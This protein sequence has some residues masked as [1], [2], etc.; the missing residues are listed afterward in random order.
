[1]N[2]IARVTV[3]VATLVAFAPTARAVELYPTVAVTPAP[4]MQVSPLPAV[5]LRPV[6]V[7]PFYRIVQSP[8]PGV[9]VRVV[10][11]TEP[12]AVEPLPANDDR[13]PRVVAGAGFGGVL[14][15]GGGRGMLGSD[16]RLHLG[17][18]VGQALVGA[19]VDLIPEG[20][21]VAGAD[22]AAR[23]AH[24]TLGSLGLGYRFLPDAVVHPVASFS[25][26]MTA[27]SVDA[28]GAV[29]G[30][31]ALGF[32]IA[33]RVGLEFEYPIST[34]AV[35][36]GLDVSAHRRL[37]SQEGFP[38]DQQNALSFGGTLHYRF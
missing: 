15:D 16:Y 9:V 8:P 35:A 22:G 34:G 31:T 2:T 30:A 24:L 29:A 23:A 4:W 1:M 38:T 13:T 6:P 3:L 21:S 33:G 25:L 19:R 37:V 36:V 32:G 7:G 11:P 12:P 18:E 10:R 28:V 5:V 20:L 27:L 17:L 14:F 26:E